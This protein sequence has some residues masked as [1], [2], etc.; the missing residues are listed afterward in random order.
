[1]TRHELITKHPDR[2]YE[3]LDALERWTKGVPM[4]E[5][6][7]KRAVQMAVD[8]AREFMHVSKE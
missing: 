1:M 3:A 6:F 8:M 4:D 2:V 5:E 7:M